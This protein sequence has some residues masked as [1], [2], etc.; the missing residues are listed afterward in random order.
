MSHTIT[1]ERAARRFSQMVSLERQLALVLDDITRAKAHVKELQEEADGL[2]L[3][4]RKAARD[5]GELP[6]FDLWPDVRPLDEQP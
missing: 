6:L 3:R 1:Q 4:L 5:E 2:M